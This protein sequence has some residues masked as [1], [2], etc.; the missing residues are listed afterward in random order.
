MASP[1]VVTLSIGSQKV[2][3][4]EFKLGAKGDLTLRA[5]ETRELLADPAADA[6]RVSQATLAFSEMSSAMK[7]KNV[8]VYCSLPAQ[9]VFS[10]L[11]KI[12][13]V[14]PGKLKETI[15]FEA[16]Q[17]I[18]HPL[19]EVV[20]DYKSLSAPNSDEPEILLVAAKTDLLEEWTDAAH[21]AKLEASGFEL[22]PIAI[23]NAFRYN[24]GEP[25]GCSLIID[26][27][28]R[29]TNLF[30][31]EPG[32]FFFRTLSSGGT[33]LTSAVS[34]EFSENFTAAENRKREHGFVA[35]GSNYAD[36]PDPQIAKLSKVLR[37]SLT[38]L[39]AEI[40][41]AISGYRSQ[42]G[43]AAPARIYITGGGVQLGLV[44]EF[45]VEKFALPVEVLNPFQC[46]KATES[47]DNETLANIVPAM[48]EHVGLALRATVSCP[49]AFNLLPLSVERRAAKN[50]QTLA[51]ALAGACLC[52][53]LFAWGFHLNNSANMANRMVESQKPN[54]EKLTATDKAMNAARAEIQNLLAKARPLENAIR[55][56][57]YWTSVL[58]QI[59][60]KLPSEKVWIT[61]FEIG[62]EAQPKP[63]TAK[64]TA[65]QIAPEKKDQKEK[66]VIKGL[67]L[68][69]PKGIALV[70][71]FGRALQGSELF[72]VAPEQ[73]WVRTNVINPTEWAQEF[74][75]P[76]YLKNPPAASVNP[77][78]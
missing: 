31:V 76:L 9:S 68:E 14:E 43:G 70:E 49:V 47:F 20:W 46:V 64:K 23:Y 25:E 71:D 42:Q 16:Q 59:H 15:A 17:N 63:G 35:Q 55:D 19:Q 57:Q 37:N 18:P 77:L 12:L 26:L 73:E 54:F 1:R 11:V 6:S 51:I 30:F 40:A 50:H 24:Y 69:N 53:P 36:H 38:R 67:Y 3:L 45:F 60:S 48:A 32:K 52:A 7:L 4:A 72:D 10:R 44:S 8:P 27:G 41:R 2:S 22:A 56:R 34:K 28:S 75:I 65:P 58:D 62:T 66:L 21:E 5:Y 29:T 78:Q 61:S 13:H 39:H 33:A 74:M